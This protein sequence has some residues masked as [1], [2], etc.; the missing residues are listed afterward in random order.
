MR[1]RTS[2]MM[3]SDIQGV[4]GWK[5]VGG[6]GE[7]GWWMPSLLLATHSNSSF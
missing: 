7:G 4:Q 5:G 1:A 3:Q 6:W 2:K